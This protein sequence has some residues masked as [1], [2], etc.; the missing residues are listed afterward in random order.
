[1]H[2]HSLWLVARGFR[3]LSVA[4]AASSLLC[5]TQ[6]RYRPDFIPPRLSGRQVYLP[7]AR[8]L[9]PHGQRYYRA[10][11]GLAGLAFL[12]GFLGFLAEGFYGDAG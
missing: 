12:C 2:S 8:D 4:L 5:L 9:T 6:I 1:M 11:K 7:Q 10:A 3:W